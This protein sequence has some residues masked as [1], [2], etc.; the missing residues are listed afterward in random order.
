LAFAGLINDFVVPCVLMEK[1]RVSDGEGGW[2]TEWRDGM[3]FN[4]AVTY[5]STLQ[6]RVA[7]SEGMRATYTVT[8]ERNNI[9]DFHDVF[10]RLSD[11]QVFRVTSDGTDVMTPDRASFQFSQVSAEEWELA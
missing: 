9:L 4:A 2:R 1:R 8:T 7:E 10:K 5:D 11:G 3:P 6:A